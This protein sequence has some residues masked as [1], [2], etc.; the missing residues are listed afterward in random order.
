MATQEQFPSRIPTISPEELAERRRKD[1]LT[2]KAANELL[3]QSKAWGQDKSKMTE[4]EKSTFDRNLDKSLY[5][6]SLKAKQLGVTQEELD[7]MEYSKPSQLSIERYEAYLKKKGKTHEEVARKD[8]ATT[9]TYANNGKKEETRRRRRS[10]I[11]GLVDDEIQRLPNEE[12]LMKASRVDDDV[13]IDKVIQERRMKEESKNQEPV[14]NVIDVNDK[15]EK[16][17]KEAVIF[18]QPKPVDT[19]QE[20]YIP[21]NAKDVE[22]GLVY[23][24]VPLPSKGECYRHKLQKIE[25]AELT[26]NDENLIAAPQMY[27][28]GTILD[29]ILERKILNKNIKP[30][31]LCKGDRDAILLWLRLNA[32]GPEYPIYATNPRTG[33]RYDIIANLNSF[34]FL[35]FKLKGDENGHFVYKTAEGDIIKFRFLTYADE[36]DLKNNILKDVINLDTM[37]FMKDITNLRTI[38][39]TTNSLS[40]DAKQE[41]KDCL[42]D[43]V[44]ILSEN[45]MISPDGADEKNILKAVTEQMVISTV[46]VNDITDR[47]YIR[48]YI[49]HMRAGEARKYRNYIADNRP[50]VDFKMTINIPESDGGGSFDT[51]LRLE[52]TLFINV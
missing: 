41:M 47:D 27:R 17:E 6:N 28:D 3:G 40:D 29:R 32:Y 35:P 34:N 45:D 10:R 2:L 49:E 16:V 31:E 13:D 24:T 12:E 22:E 33:K 20:D 7:K 46:S 8:V 39:K 21:F 44:E 1:L 23:D 42:D 4:T 19:V 9:V 26:A 18:E 5:E 14:V 15:N 50:G 48:N 30:S 38:V 25:V 11:N 36:E 37:L 52:D 43:M 51:F